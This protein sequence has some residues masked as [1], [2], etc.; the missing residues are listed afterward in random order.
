[1]MLENW[2]WLPNE[3][4]AIGRHYTRVDPIYME[5][6]LKDNPG[7]DTPSEKI[8]DELLRHHLTRYRHAKVEV[9]LGMLYVIIPQ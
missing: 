8:P 5:T 9:L 3:L 1:M 6:W 4:K 2:C 7:R